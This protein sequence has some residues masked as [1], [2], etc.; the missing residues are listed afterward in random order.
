MQV[1]QCLGSL[2]YEFRLLKLPKVFPRFG[3]Q[4][5]GFKV[6]G[7]RFGLQGLGSKVWAPRFGVQGLGSKV[8]PPRF[9]VQGLGSKVWAPRFGVQ[10]LGSNFLEIFGC[11]ETSILDVNLIANGQIRAGP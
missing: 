3:F 10:G 4:G 6:L 7:P 9:G 11:P 2:N 8:C 1:S 5:S